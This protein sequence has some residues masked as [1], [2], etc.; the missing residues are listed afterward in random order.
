AMSASDLLTADEKERERHV[1]AI[2]ARLDEIGRT[3]RIDVPVYFL[4]TKCDLVAGFSEFFDDLGQDQRAQ[5]WGATFPI[6]VTESGH[7]PG[8]FEKEFSRLLERLQQHVLGRMERER[9]ARR[10]VGILAFP[11]QMATFGPLLSELL[12]R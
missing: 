12:E 4:V 1:T 10:R 5:V 7:A 3:L 9:D 8:L 2:R 6:E 11:Q